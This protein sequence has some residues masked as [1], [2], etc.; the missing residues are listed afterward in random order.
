MIIID[1]VTTLMRFFENLLLNLVFDYYEKL[2]QNFTPTKLIGDSS[3]QL[4]LKKRK[5]ECDRELLD[6]EDECN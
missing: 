1:K 6:I 4:G 5:R 2:I 3:H